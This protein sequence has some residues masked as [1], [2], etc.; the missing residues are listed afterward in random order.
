MPPNLPGISAGAKR[1]H[2]EADTKGTEVADLERK[3]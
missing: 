1:A 3:T 2:E